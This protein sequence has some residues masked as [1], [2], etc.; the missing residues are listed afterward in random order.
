MVTMIPIATPMSISSC[1]RGGVGK[2][3]YLEEFC[4]VGHVDGVHLQGDEGVDFCAE[5]VLEGE[6]RPL[7]GPPLAPLGGRRGAG[8]LARLDP[9][10]QVVLPTPQ[11]VVK[12]VPLAP[13]VLEVELRTIFRSDLKLLNLKSFGARAF[14]SA[15][16]D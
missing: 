16:Y 10:L 14:L 13:E 5:V 4:E 9:V 6:G 8:R 1:E 3:H 11:D 2:K 12:H 15:K 7:F